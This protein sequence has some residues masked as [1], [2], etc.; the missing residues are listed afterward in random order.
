MLVAAVQAPVGSAAAAR[1][2]TCAPRQAKVKL[3]KGDTVVYTV[4]RHVHEPEIG[5]LLVRAFVACS[6]ATRAKVPLGF[7][8]SDSSVPSAESLD[9]FTVAGPYLAY[10]IHYTTA[11]GSAGVGEREAGRRARGK[12]VMNVYANSVDNPNSVQ[13]LALL[14]RADGAGLAELRISARGSCAAGRVATLRR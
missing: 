3:S 2:Q 6:Q 1:S 8:D 10:A 12:K 5:T 13:I 4:R 11:V 7:V 14:V 9:H